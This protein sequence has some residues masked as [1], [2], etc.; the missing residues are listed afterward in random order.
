MVVEVVIGM[1][2]WQWQRNSGGEEEDV[3]V[4]AVLIGVKLFGEMR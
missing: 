2:G 4:A 1:R 3:G